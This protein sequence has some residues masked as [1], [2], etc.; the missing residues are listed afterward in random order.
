MSSHHAAREAAEAGYR[1][2]FVR[3][4]GIHGWETAGKRVESGAPA[5]RSTAAAP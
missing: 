5:P 1:K 3:P 4:E 2:V